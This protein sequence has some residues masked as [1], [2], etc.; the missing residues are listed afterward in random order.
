MRSGRACPSARRK[1]LWIADDPQDANGKRRRWRALRKLN[2]QL[3]PAVE[4]LRQR[5]AEQLT[6]CEQERK[7]NAILRRRYYPFCL[8]P[9]AELRSFLIRSLQNAADGFS[10]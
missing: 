2:E 6:R 7:A 10:G 5:T 9:E 3:Q 4:S 1:R 8:Y